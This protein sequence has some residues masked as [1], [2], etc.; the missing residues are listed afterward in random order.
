M[1]ER[2]ERPVDATTSARRAVTI[3]LS[4]LLKKVTHPNPWSGVGRVT[5]FVL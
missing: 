4:K 5:F 3:T 2:C 1:T